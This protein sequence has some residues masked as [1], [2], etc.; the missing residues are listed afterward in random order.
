MTIA[1]SLIYVTVGP[2]VLGALLIM[3]L[4]IPFN[5]GFSL[6]IRSYQV[7]EESTNVELTWA[8]RERLAV[9]SCLHVNSSARNNG[10]LNFS[11]ISDQA[12]A[13]ERQSFKIHKRGKKWLAIE[14][15]LQGVLQLP[16]L[17]HQNYSSARVQEKKTGL[18][19]GR[20]LMCNFD[21]AA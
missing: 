4:Y 19:L 6:I 10:L 9:S 14:L 13:N 18:K 21:G 16:T 7:R 5:Y 3:V 17:M 1:L 8:S 15:P 20:D 12:D 2:P 11:T